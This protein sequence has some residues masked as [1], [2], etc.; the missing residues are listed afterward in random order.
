MKANCTNFYHCWYSKS[1]LTVTHQSSCVNLI[2]PIYD[3]KHKLT[4]V[5]AEQKNFLSTVGLNFHIFVIL[6]DFIPSQINWKTIECINTF[7]HKPFSV[8]LC[9]SSSE[10]DVNDDFD[11]SFLKRR[12]LPKNKTLPIKCIVH[13]TGFQIASN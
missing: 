4:Y 10:I 9:A 1:H 11:K 7:N 3:Q 8:A 12:M 13:S 6:K 2:Y 5:Y